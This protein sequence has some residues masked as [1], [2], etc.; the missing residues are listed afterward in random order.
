MGCYDDQELIQAIFTQ[1]NSR[2]LDLFASLPTPNRDS[3]EQKILEMAHREFALGKAE[4]DQDQLLPDQYAQEREIAAVSLPS[5]AYTT[6]CK[7]FPD[8]T[9]KL[10]ITSGRETAFSALG[11]FGL[12]GFFIFLFSGEYLVAFLIFLIAGSSGFLWSKTDDY[13]VLNPKE[14]MLYY[15]KKFLGTTEMEPYLPFSHISTLAVE[16]AFHKGKD[17]SWWTYKAVAISKEGEMIDLSDDKKNEFNSCREY[18]NILSKRMGVPCLEAVPESS[19]TIAGSG[20][21]I[22]IGYE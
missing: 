11:C 16:G 3:V 9:W 5:S 4:L 15:H 2:H 19:L 17:S 14:Q 21:R 8:G 6:Q 22:H 1:I 10:E 20:S 13:L 18:V 12:I 7:E